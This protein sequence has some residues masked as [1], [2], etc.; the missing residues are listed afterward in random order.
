MRFTAL[1]EYGLRC[2]LH[3]ARRADAAWI[4][5]GG[6][7][8]DSTD[9]ASNAPRSSEGSKG[10]GGAGSPKDAGGAGSPSVTLGEVAEGEGLTQQYTGK[11]FRILA[12]GGLVESERGRKGGYR[13]TRRP[14]EITVSEVLTAAGG[15]F[16]DREVCGR[17]TGNRESCVHAD[18]C[19]IRRVWAD[20]QKAVDRVLTGLT[21]RDLVLEERRTERRTIVREVFSLQGAHNSPKAEPSRVG[22][23]RERNTRNT[24]D[25]GLARS[26]V[27]T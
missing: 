14:D 27:S 12:R 7:P 24:D 5:G 16:F 20:I 18:H 13:L 3:L 25:G 15:R 17:Y 8:A 2:M 6:V 11:I 21:L 19:A 4:D 23:S 9:A 1:E 26:R 22:R 10:A